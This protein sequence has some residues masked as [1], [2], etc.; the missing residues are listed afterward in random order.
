[1]LPQV[2]ATLAFPL[3]KKLP[4][5]EAELLKMLLLVIATLATS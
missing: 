1:M 5:L 2:M 4:P 3:I